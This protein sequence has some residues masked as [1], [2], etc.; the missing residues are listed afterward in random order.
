MKPTNHWRCLIA[1]LIVAVVIAVPISANA[2]GPENLE[3]GTQFMAL[4][5]SFLEVIE[6]THSVYGDPEKSAIFHL[7]KIQEIY[8]KKGEP[9]KAAEVFNNVLKTSKNKTVRNSA[10][11]MLADVLKDSGNH[12]EAISVLKQGLQENLEAAQ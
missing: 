7:H 6:T 3:R 8:K 2:V 9:K 1:S 10:Y 4:I 12:D 11:I 5:K